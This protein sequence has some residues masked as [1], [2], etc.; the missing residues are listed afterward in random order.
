M[1]RVDAVDGYKE[2]YLAIQWV[3]KQQEVVT[4]Y[5]VI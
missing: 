4:Y 1:R 5:A 3:L 2:Q